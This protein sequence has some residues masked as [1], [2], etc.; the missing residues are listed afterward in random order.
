[1]IVGLR[2]DSPDAEVHVF[3]VGGKKISSH[4]WH[5][6]RAL[7]KDLLAVIHGQLQAAG[8]DWS[9]VTGVIVFEG[10]GSFTG[11]RIG[12]TVANTL[13]YVRGVPIIAAKGNE[14]LHIGI[15]RLNNNEN[16]QLALPHY[17]AEAHITQPKK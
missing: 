6:G 17:G 12:I 8:A 13:A 11:L 3:A 2:T 16:D 10:P 5:A 1:M 9:D 7:G 15:R 4:V 14:W